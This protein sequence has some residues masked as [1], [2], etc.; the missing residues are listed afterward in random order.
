MNFELFVSLRYLL[1]KRRQ[2]FISLITLISI[3][4]VAVGVTALIVVLAVMN[5]FQEDLRTRILG[6]T[7]HV[8]VGSFKGAI[9]DYRAVN[10]QIE[11][12]PGVVA[13]TPFVYTQVMISSGKNVAGAILRGI[14]PQTAYK[15]INIQD[16]MIRGSLGDLRAPSAGSDETGAVQP[17]I[18]LGNELANNLGVR[19]G[20]WVTIISPAGRLTPMGQ[21]PKSKLFQVVGI[22]QAGMYEYDNTLAYIH[23]ETAQQFLGIGDVVTGIEVKVKDIYNAREIADGLRSRLKDSFWVRDWMQMNQNLF[24]ALKLEKAVMFI[25]LTLIILVAA[26]NIVSSLIMLV[27]EKTRDIA[28]LK[29][30]GA[31]TASIRK[32]FV[33]EGLLIGVSGTILGL[34]GGFGLCTILKKY[35]F[36]ELPRDVYYFSTLPV[37][38]EGTDVALIALSAIAISLTATLYPS[39]QAA[40]L[41][42]S[43]ALRYE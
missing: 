5:G 32:I 35:Q 40:K 43:E 42:P 3:A 36:I 30:M 10:A 31:T 39:R 4:G 28:I 15:V 20:D 19:H 16:N 26:F 33:L 11:K 25:I 24:S 6:V 2:T 34:L 23:L 14:D 8:V 27:M 21:V 41:D 9:T 22:I 18:I 7:S 37:K 17:G 13:A 12:E 29:A 38:L 1:A